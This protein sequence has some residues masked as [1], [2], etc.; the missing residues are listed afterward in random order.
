[1]FQVVSINDDVLNDDDELTQFLFELG[2]IPP[3]IALPLPTQYIDPADVLLQ[4]WIPYTAPTMEPATLD[5]F[6]DKKQVFTLL[7]GS[8][9]CTGGHC[10]ELMF[11]VFFLQLLENFNGAHLLGDVDYFHAASERDNGK[12][13]L[14]VINLR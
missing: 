3:V 13:N 11:F 2:A 8:V 6:P 9:P 5:D 12:L 7:I 1:M 10:K 4:H 14:F